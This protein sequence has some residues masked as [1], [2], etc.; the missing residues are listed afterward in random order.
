LTIADA[1]P[2]MREHMNNRSSVH[3]SA[4]RR[5]RSAGHG[6]SPETSPGRRGAAPREPA[7]ETTPTSAVVRRARAALASTDSVDRLA[8]TFRALGDPT[9]SKLVLALSI[10]EMC[11]TD[12][13]EA[14]G[15]SL[16]ATSHQLRIL[17]DLDI[18]RVRRSGKTQM[19]ALNEQAFGFCAPRL[20]IAWRQTLDGARPVRLADRRSRS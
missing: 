18:V 16:S 2:R 8:R 5:P 15:A 14:L 9:R 10:E 11:V 1:S 4:R 19:Y 3:A 7:R 13:A 20:C 6:S 12:L 17:R